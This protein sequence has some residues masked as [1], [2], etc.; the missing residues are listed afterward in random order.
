MRE[1]HRRVGGLRDKDRG[2]REIDRSPVEIE[3]IA[4]RNDEADRGFLYAEILQLRHHPRQDRFGRR[5]PEHDQ[6]LFL[7]VTDEFQ[8]AESVVARNEPEHDKNENE[9][10]EIERTHQLAERQQ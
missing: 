8:D 6:E 3:R 10:G 1:G 2:H 9:A 4:G 5:R 7:D